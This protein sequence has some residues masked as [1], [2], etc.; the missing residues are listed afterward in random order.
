MWKYVCGNVS[1]PKRA[2]RTPHRW[3]VIPTEWSG[4]LTPKQIAKLF[5]EWAHPIGIGSVAIRLGLADKTVTSKFRQ[6]QA[7]VAECE[8]TYRDKLVFHDCQVDADG[9]SLRRIAKS[10]V[11]KKTIKKKG[12]KKVTKRVRVREGTQHYGAAIFARRGSNQCVV[13]P[14][15]GD[16]VKVGRGGKPGPPPT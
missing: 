16:F 10:K 6:I 12:K 11:V 9:T 2:N 15:P 4:H 5:W 1:C 14:T 13:H 8:K 7:A 3:S